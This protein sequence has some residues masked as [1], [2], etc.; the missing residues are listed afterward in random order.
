MLLSLQYRTNLLVLFVVCWLSITLYHFGVVCCA[1]FNVRSVG[2][3]P[4]YADIITNVFIIVKI[5][6]GRF[7]T[8]SLSL[9]FIGGMAYTLHRLISI[10][11]TCLK[12]LYACLQKTTMNVLSTNTSIKIL[13]ARYKRKSL[14]HCAMY[15]GFSMFIL[16]LQHHSLA[17]GLSYWLQWCAAGH[18]VILLCAPFP[19]P[20]N[21]KPWSVRR[22]RQYWQ[23]RIC[24]P[25][26][27]QS[28]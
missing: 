19:N 8:I 2:I 28:W 4:R 10:V 22:V 3:I 27:W 7:V 5:L 20:L 1:C 24:L 23:T 14:I 16:I 26:R 25:A 15:Q 17:A 18:D 6:I 11:R 9:K 21:P 12:R 13:Y